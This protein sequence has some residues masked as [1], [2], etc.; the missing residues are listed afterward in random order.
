MP[1]SECFH[2]HK[3]NNSSKKLC[4]DCRFDKNAMVTYTDIKKIYKLTE[5]EIDKT[6]VYHETFRTKYGSKGVVYY[7]PDIIKFVEEFAKNLPDTDPT[8]KAVIKLNIEQNEK[9][10]KED[11]EKFLYC[12][13]L[14]DVKLN[15]SKYNIPKEFLEI[16]YIQKTIKIKIINFVKNHTHNNNQDLF[17][18]N[19]LECLDSMY[20]KKLEIEEKIEDLIDPFYKES[21]KKHPIYLN[22]IIYD[23]NNIDICMSQL[24]HDQDRIINQEK[25]EKKFEIFLKDF[26]DKNSEFFS[27]KYLNLIQSERSNYVNNNKI[28]YDICIEKIEK[29][30]YNVMIQN[31][32]SN[33]HKRLNAA[34][35]KRI[36]LADLKKNYDDKNIKNIKN[37]NYIVKKMKK[38]EIKIIKK[39]NKIID[40]I[41]RILEKYYDSNNIKDYLYNFSTHQDLIVITNMF[42]DKKFIKNQNQNIDDNID[43]YILGKIKYKDAYRNIKCHLQNIEEH[44]LNNNGNNMTSENIINLLKQPWH[45]TNN[46]KKYILLLDKNLSPKEI[47]KEAKIF[48]FWN[49]MYRKNNWT[50]L[51]NEFIQTQIYQN[52]LEDNGKNFNYINREF[53]MYIMK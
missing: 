23:H 46:I 14:N 40:K 18:I 10:K 42:I 49:E 34:T 36:S 28:D 6:K 24:L 43:N 7:I 9:Q 38:N 35:G 45:M 12:F 51:K 37:M 11:A 39:Y 15:L 32:L 47:I 17:V 22:Y 16:D 21:A 3:Q 53:Q 48:H 5:D 1:L 13:I 29:M 44:I 33:M 31:E 30:L 27:P 41:E 19:I 2:C 25:R 4:Q 50:K 26:T 8:K 20:T 52:Y